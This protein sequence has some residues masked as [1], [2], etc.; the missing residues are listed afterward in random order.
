MP[1]FFSVEYIVL[2]FLNEFLNCKQL[3]MEYKPLKEG[4]VPQDEVPLYVEC[5]TWLPETREPE[6]KTR[7]SRHRAGQV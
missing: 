5:P 7:E 6:K 3:Y 2:S 1:I 4:Y